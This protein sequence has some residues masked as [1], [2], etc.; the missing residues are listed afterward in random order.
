MIVDA[1]LREVYSGT[2]PLDASPPV[3]EVSEN[4]TRFFSSKAASPQERVRVNVT[5]AIRTAIAHVA[6]VHSAL[7]QY[8][9]HTIKTGTFCVY[10][11]EPHMLLTWEF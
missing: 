10:V 3:R 11:P 2:Q 9:T 8:L 5:R 7:G 1:L 6:E 4:L